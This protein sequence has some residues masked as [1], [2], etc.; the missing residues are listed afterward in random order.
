MT[1][2]YRSPKPKWNIDMTIADAKSISTLLT[3]MVVG[4]VNV[5]SLHAQE[6]PAKGEHPPI[7]A[8][9]PATISDGK[10]SEF[11]FISHT[12][13]CPKYFDRFG[14]GRT[15]TIEVLL[16]DKMESGKRYPVLYALAPLSSCRSSCCRPSW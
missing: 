2:E 10:L 4:L 5:S 11:G 1:F 14:K 3:T 15:E 16:P 8:T 13:D 12:I 7:P 9:I 6:E